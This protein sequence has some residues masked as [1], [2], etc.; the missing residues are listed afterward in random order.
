VD[1][2]KGEYNH[3]NV[4]LSYQLASVLGGSLPPLVLSLTGYP[5]VHV[6]LP[7]ALITALSFLIIKVEG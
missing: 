6:V 5:I 4:N 1:L 3:T 2:F 7:Y